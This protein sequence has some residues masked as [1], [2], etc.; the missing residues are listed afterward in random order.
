MF[1]GM[2]DFDFAQNLIKFAQILITF[3][4]ISPFVEI[5]TKFRPNFAQK[6]FLRDAA[7]FPIPAALY[8]RILIGYTF[9]MGLPC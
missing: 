3:V 7:A 8:T 1:L 9:E 4:Q 6:N 5:F 2:Q